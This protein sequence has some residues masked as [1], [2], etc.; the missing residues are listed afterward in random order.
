LK[1]NLECNEIIVVTS[2]NHSDT[3]FLVV[4][5]EDPSYP[6]RENEATLKITAAAGSGIEWAEKHFGVRLSNY[7]SGGIVFRWV[8]DKPTVRKMDE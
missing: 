4:D 1:L 7:G 2:K 3:I 6:F 5:L 8:K